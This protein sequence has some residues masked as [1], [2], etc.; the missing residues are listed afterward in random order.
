MSKLPEGPS[1]HRQSDLP[2]LICDPSRT[3]IFSNSNKLAL[4]SIPPLSLLSM[5]LFHRFSVS[6]K[7]P[8][9]VVLIRV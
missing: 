4:L 1:A 8:K 7:V 6:R 3:K 2:R 5:A 9:C